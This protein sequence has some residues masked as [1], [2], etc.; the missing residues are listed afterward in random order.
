MQKTTLAIALVALSIISLT[1]GCTSNSHAS[2]VNASRA[3][4]PE[5]ALGPIANVANP[6]QV[7]RPIDGYLPE[8]A[9]IVLLVIAEQNAINVCL[10]HQNENTSFQ[11]SEDHTALA[12]YVAGGVSDRVTR[13]NLWGFF[14]TRSV[15]A[16]GYTRP[17]TTPSSLTAYISPG[18]SGESVARCNQEVDK[19][20]PNASTGFGLADYASLPDKGPLV[21]ASDSRYVKVVAAWSACMSSAG[22]TYPDPLAAVGDTTWQTA[23]TNGLATVSTDQ[24]AAATADINCKISTNLVGVGL[25]VQSAYDQQY[26]DAKRQALSGYQEL[27]DAFLRINVSPAGDPSTSAP[28]Q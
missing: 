19:K 10:A 5:P 15:R 18:G 16:S 3:A 6:A 9:Q 2:S 24:I 22:Y 13:S 25:A 11:F 17:E 27:L 7:K 23:G 21:P 4:V 20:L 14:D 12:A 8:A 26:I 28:S 1:T